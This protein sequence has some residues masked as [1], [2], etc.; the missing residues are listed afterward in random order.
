MEYW[1]SYGVEPASTGDLIEGGEL[2]DNSNISAIPYDSDGS[3]VLVNDDKRDS[4]WIDS[5]QTYD[6]GQMR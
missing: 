4:E 3:I 1:H 6:L 5:G 2:P